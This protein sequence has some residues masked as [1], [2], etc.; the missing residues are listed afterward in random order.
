MNNTE[1]PSDRDVEEDEK[2][3][4]IE[5]ETEPSRL[6]KLRKQLNKLNDQEFNVLIEIKAAEQLQEWLMDGICE[7]TDGCMVEPDGICPHG[8]NSWLLELGLI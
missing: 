3:L 4:A 7:A 2:D 6:E 8:C 5:P 1:T